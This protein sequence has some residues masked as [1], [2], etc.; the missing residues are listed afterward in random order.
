MGFHGLRALG[1]CLV[2]LCIDV[3][4][5]R[6][7]YAVQ[8]SAVCA[9]LVAVWLPF[10]FL[11]LFEVLCLVL[12]TMVGFVCCGYVVAIWLLCRLLWLS[13]T[14]FGLL[15]C[16]VVRTV[17][18]ALWFGGFSGFGLDFG[19]FCLF[20]FGFLCAASLVCYMW[21]WFGLVFSGFWSFVVLVC[22][23]C[24]LRLLVYFYVWLLCFVVAWVLWFD[25]MVAFVIASV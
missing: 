5:F 19:C 1:S 22:F 25:L 3:F 13:L 20:S 12:L 2:R 11:L 7:F 16:L 10:G 23:C 18:W 24:C 9:D 8:I 4:N 17:C 14:L 21:V 15:E 6:L